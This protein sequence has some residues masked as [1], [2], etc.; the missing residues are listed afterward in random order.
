MIELLMR[1]ML[2]SIVAALAAPLVG[3]SM[4]SWWSLLYFTIIGF[5]FAITDEF[6]DWAFKD[7]NR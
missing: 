7:R 4:T 3:I 1:C 5:G 6:V 2:W